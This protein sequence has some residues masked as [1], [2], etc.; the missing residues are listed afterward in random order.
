[1]EKARDYD[2]LREVFKN[3]GR[4]ITRKSLIALM[5]I[6]VLSLFYVFLSFLSSLEAILLIVLSE[7]NFLIERKLFEILI[8][9][10]YG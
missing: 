7:T 2:H 4:N 5:Q 1:M 6:N 3:T 10:W 9:M 8:C